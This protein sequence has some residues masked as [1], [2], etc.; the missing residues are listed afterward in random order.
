MPV[1]DTDHRIQPKRT[2]LLNGRVDAAE[3]LDQPDLDERALRHNLRDIERV[4]RYFGGVQTVLRY[5]KPLLLGV[6]ADRHI[7][8]LDLGTGAADIPAAISRWAAK[9]GLQL[10]ICA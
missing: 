10:D 3:L 2:M 9:T 7:S 1:L 5:L 4:N 8:I 6:S